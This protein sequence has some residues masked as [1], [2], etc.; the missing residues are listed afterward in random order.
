MQN[1]NDIDF[2]ILAFIYQNEPV[3]I[4]NIQKHFPKITALEH[5]LDKLC[6]RE[7][8]GFGMPLPNSSYVKEQLSAT[9][10]DDRGLPMRLGIYETTDFGK[11]TAQDYLHSNKS[12]QKD[13]HRSW[14]QF[15]M[16]LMVSI[17]ALFRPEITIFIEWIM[18]LF[19]Q[20]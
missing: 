5:R 13:I 2:Q 1:F 14:I 15:W 12:H 6:R 8:G 17:L 20:K 18:G 4:S 19:T 9:E 10:K 3:H 7:I 11:T 16:P